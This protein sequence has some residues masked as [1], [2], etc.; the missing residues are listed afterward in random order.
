VRGA[1]RQHLTH[2][3][4]AAT[5]HHRHIPE[6]VIAHLLDVPR[7]YVHHGHTLRG[8]CSQPHRLHRPQLPLVFASCRVVI[9]LRE[10]RRVSG[11]ANTSHALPG[12][13]SV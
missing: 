3:T 7:R 9:H 11:R 4:S 8:A 1:H 12:V 5:E 10:Q 2:E 6:E 13:P